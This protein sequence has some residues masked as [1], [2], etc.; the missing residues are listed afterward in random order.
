MID[1]SRFMRLA[2]EQARLARDAGEVPVG[3][4]VTRG[5]EILAAAHNLPISSLDPS[6]HAEILALRQAGG[7]VGNYRLVGTTLYCTVE[8][9]LMCLGASI[10][11]RI[12]RL[13]YGAT[14][15]K[16]S[17]LAGLERLR[18]E[19]AVLNHQFEVRGGVLAEEIAVIMK[20]FFRQRRQES[21]E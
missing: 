4:V 1:D 13:V 15:P 2:I 7:R 9:C 18:N 6:A 10:H 12:D 16:V 17:S 14:D 19:G 11:A 20:D 5:S 8:P 21:S 3:A